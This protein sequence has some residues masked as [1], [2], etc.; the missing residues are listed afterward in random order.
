[1]GR[2]RGIRYAQRDVLKKV[3]LE[4]KKRYNIP[5]QEINRL[6]KEFEG[7]NPENIEKLSK[8]F[9]EVQHEKIV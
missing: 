3:I 4:L 8:K 6:L 9:I 2:V 7:F 5:H 1:M